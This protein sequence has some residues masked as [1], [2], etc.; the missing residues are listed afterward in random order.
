MYNLNVFKE[1]RENNSYIIK[2]FQ[3][4]LFIHVLNPCIYILKTA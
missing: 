3:F 4:I 2:S 1:G